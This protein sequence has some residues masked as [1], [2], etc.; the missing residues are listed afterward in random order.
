M[1][2]VLPPDLLSPL[3]NLKDPEPLQSCLAATTW[4]LAAA[5][6]QLF[7]LAG[8]MERHICRCLVT[9][10][11][12][13]PCCYPCQAQGHSWLLVTLRLHVWLGH[14]NSCSVPSCL[15][16]LSW[17]WFANL[18]AN[19]TISNN[20]LFWALD[21]FR[22]TVCPQLPPKFSWADCFQKGVTRGDQSELKTAKVRSP[23]LKSQPKSSSPE[24]YVSFTVLGTLSQT[25]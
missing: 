16:P 19:P 24:H 5:P 3:S 1:H 25:G 23:F 6:E 20:L 2:R 13:V 10:C 18:W 7:S 9:K 4:I 14:E 22:C 11:F 21:V 8:N 12:S 17:R 15:R